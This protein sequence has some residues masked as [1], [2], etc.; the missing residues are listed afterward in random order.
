ML[1][2]VDGI[3]ISMSTLRRHLKLLALFRPGKKAQSDLLEVSLFLQE[4]LNQRFNPSSLFVTCNHNYKEQSPWNVIPPVPPICPLKSLNRTGMVIN[5]CVCGTFPVFSQFCDLFSYFA[6]NSVLR[7]HL[8]LSFDY[9]DNRWSDR[10]HHCQLCCWGL[11]EVQWGVRSC[12]Q[13]GIP[14]ARQSACS[15]LN[16]HYTRVTNHH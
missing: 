7:R 2:N 12:K 8:C 16:R 4:Q 15:I 9:L 1:I 10:L 6:N 3:N 13:A 14:E 5:V 11:K